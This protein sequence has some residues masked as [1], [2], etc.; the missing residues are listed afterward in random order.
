MLRR[1]VAVAV[2]LIFAAAF[3]LGANAQENQPS[4]GLPQA[5][6]AIMSEAPSKDMAMP[7]MDQGGMSKTGM[8]F[9]KAMEKMHMDMMPGM[10]AKDPD[11]AFACSMIPHHQSAIEM[12]QA[13]L[14]DGK[15]ADLKKLAEKIIEDQK[16]E[17]SQ[18]RAKL[19][20]K[21]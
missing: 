2:A 4:A 19:D 9:M 17:I 18:L 21:S 5:C 8:A 11:V 14:D 10:H 3:P 6:R 7:K 1:Q 13:F 20:K 12:A 16:A 15:D